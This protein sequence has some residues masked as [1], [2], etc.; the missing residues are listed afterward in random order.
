MQNDTQF[1]SGILPDTRPID[2]QLKDYK[3]EETV[4][5]PAPVIWKEKKLEELRSF[6]I[7]NQDGSGSCVAQTKAKEMGVLH[8]LKYG[9]YKHFSASHIY[10]RRANKPAAGM[11]GDDVHK[12]ASQGVTFE[13]YMPSQNMSDAQMDN[14]QPLQG[15]DKPENQFKISGY[16]KLDQVGVIDTIASI[17]QQTGKG[18]MVWFYFDWNATEWSTDTP[19]IKFPE[20]SL[21]GK[22][23]ARHS[24]FASDFFLLNGK[25]CLYADDSWGV[26]FGRG[27]HRIITEDFF[28]KRN[29][30]AAY[31]MDFAFN[32][33]TTQPDK[34]TYTF[35]KTLAFSPTVFYDKDVAALQNIL[36]YEGLFP[37]NVQSTGYY[38]AMTAK[39]VLAFQK[40]YNVAPLAELNQLQ[41]RVV[42]NKTLAKLKQL[43]G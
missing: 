31:S 25:K 17:I 10:Q 32:D 11:S 28:Q 16:L 40:K 1:N 26:N 8:F 36:K 24:I 7:F 42:G 20:L 34:P 30:Y 9:I 12:I 39:A 19:V 23:T 33:S 15:F 22:D 29:F 38:G 18:V 5:A 13:E 27:G 21:Y 4:S 37:T 6:P 35:T 41:G 43:Y 2:Q 14:A 3:F